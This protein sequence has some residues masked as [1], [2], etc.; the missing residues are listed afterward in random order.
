VTAS[1]ANA[2]PRRSVLNGALLGIAATVVGGGALGCTSGSASGPT[3]SPSP[4]AQ[5]SGPAANGTAAAARTLLAYF[6]RAGENYHYG[7]RRRLEVGN[8]EILARTISRLS[9][10]DV[11]RIEAADP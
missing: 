1:P 4:S 11:H 10:C 8:T 7:G 3:S 5:Q 9:G 6:S 2:L